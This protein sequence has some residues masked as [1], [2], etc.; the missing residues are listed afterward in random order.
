MKLARFLLL[1]LL[2]A[3]F[4]GFALGSLIRMRIEQKPASYFVGQSVRRPLGFATAQRRLQ[5]MSS[6][7]ARPFSVRAITNSRS[8]NRFR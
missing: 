7:P 2:G 1:A 5:G 4:A 8:D 6:T 3:L